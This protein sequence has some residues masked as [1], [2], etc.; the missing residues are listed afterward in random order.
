MAKKRLP[1]FLTAMAARAVDFVLPPRCPASGEIVDAPGMISPAA[2]D[3]LRFIA[4]P[5]CACCGLPFGFDGGAGVDALCLACLKERPLFDSARAAVAYDD[6]SRELILRFKHGDQTHTVQSFIPWLRRAGRDMLA[7]ADALVPVPLH[8]GRLLK[9]RYNQAALIAA[10]LA[11]EVGRPWLPDTLRRTRATEIQGRMN[12]RA[13]LKNVRRAFAV[14]PQRYT[15]VAGRRIVLVDDVYTTG[16]TV[17]ECARA[18]RVAG[19]ASVHVLTVAR[20]VRD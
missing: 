15:D 8:R 19:A 18:L 16:A 2:W 9:R 17:A 5:L 4:D 6:G 10:A 12:A 14:P 7:Q 13:R 11:R 1:Q 3:R 20:V